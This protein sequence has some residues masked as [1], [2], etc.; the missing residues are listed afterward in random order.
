MKKILAIIFTV[1][2][3]LSLVSCDSMESDAKKVAK[4]SYEVQK[5]YDNGGLSKSEEK[6]S[7]EFLNKMLEKYGKDK[8]TKEK[9]NNLVKKELKKLEDKD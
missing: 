2:L 3:S 6:E 5:S 9:F 1:V 8:E 7:I 4:K